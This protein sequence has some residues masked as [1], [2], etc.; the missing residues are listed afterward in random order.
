MVVKA[1]FK[2]PATIIVPL[3][4]SLVSELLTMS[5]KPSPLNTS[6]SGKMS[7]PWQDVSE[8]DVIHSMSNILELSGR[9]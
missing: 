1:S 7:F 9:I 4:Y 6:A 3:W 2:F 8:I 5:G